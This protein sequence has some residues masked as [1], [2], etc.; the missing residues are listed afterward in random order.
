[1]IFFFSIAG[2]SSRKRRRAPYVDDD[3]IEERLESLIARVGEK[4]MSIYFKFL[5]S[6]I[7][8]KWVS[9][10]APSPLLATWKTLLMFLLWI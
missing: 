8:Y 5:S 6:L 2:R 7:T 3:D 10:R 4:V 9:F 1:L